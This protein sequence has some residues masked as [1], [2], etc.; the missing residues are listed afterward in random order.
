MEFFKIV[1]TT[2]TEN[3]IQEK[4]TLKNLE[5][6]S[7]EIFNLEE[8]GEESSFIGGLWGEFTLTRQKIKGGVRFALAEC[9]NALCWTVTTGYPPKREAVVVHLTINRVQKQAE[10]IDEINEFLDD[11]CSCLGSFL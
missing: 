5:N 10:F 2:T 1:D 6:Y 11:H 8:P 3:R 4:L 7:T 9:P